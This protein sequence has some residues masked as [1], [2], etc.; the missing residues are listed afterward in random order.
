MPQSPTPPPGVRVAL[1]SCIPDPSPQP[2]RVCRESINGYPWSGASR[3]LFAARLCEDSFDCRRCSHT[4]AAGARALQ[5]RRR[6]RHTGA[7][8]TQA[9]HAAGATQALQ[10]RRCCRH[11][12][13][14]GT[15]ALQTSRHCRRSGTTQALQGARCRHAGAAVAEL[16]SADWGR[17]CRRS[18]IAV[19]A[20]QKRRATVLLV[21][22][23]C[24]AVVSAR[25]SSSNTL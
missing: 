12:G 23:A 19:T 25:V 18:T 21:V 6:C 7:V 3:M 13:A 17:S 22:F 24:T 14:A 9:L 20:S 2:V 8:D 10:A 4:G 16:T 1:H 15:R 11:A 5:A